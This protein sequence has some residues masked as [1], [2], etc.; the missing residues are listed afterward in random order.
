MLREREAEVDAADPRALR[1][2]EDVEAKANG[3]LDAYA[4]GDRPPGLA[5][6]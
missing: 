4:V 3:V 5:F 6:A 2:V 1:S